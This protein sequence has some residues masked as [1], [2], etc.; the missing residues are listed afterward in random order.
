MHYRRALSQGYI[1]KLFVYIFFVSLLYH[2]VRQWLGVF[3][4]KKY[5]LDQFIISIFLTVVSLSGFFGEM[6]GGRLSDRLGRIPVARSGVLFM[7]IATSC[8]I[9]KL[10]FWV[11]LLVMVIWGLGWTFNHSSISSL[12]TDLPHEF[13]LE[14]TSLNSSVRFLAG[15]L[16]VVVGG[17]LMQRSFELG[18][19]ICAILFLILFGFTKSLKL[20]N[21]HEEVG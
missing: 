14:A 15:G 3:F 8:L 6:A 12:I 16:G 7:I 20:A 18:F 19:T 1:L 17:L 2:A 5:Y 9:F 21:V 10:P 11:L 4:F 13:L